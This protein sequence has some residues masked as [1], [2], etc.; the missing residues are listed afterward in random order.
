MSK[1]TLSWLSVIAILAVPGIAW[2]NRYVIFDTWRL[3]N[4]TPPTEIV[5]LADTTTMTG[6]TRR[7]F[8]VYQPLLA[9]KSS[10]STFCTESEQTIVLG[11]YIEHRGIYLYDVPDE[12]LKGVE[13]VTAAHEVLHAVYDRLSRS[14]R[15]RIDTLVLQAFEGIED[16]KLRQT[17][18]NYRKKDPSVVPNELHSILA[19]EVR[20]LPKQ[21]EDHYR[22]YFSDRLAV[23]KLAESYR[24]EFTGREQEVAAL[25]QQLASIKQQIDALN[26]SL[27]QQQISL[28]TSYDTLQND[29]QAGN[30]A[31]YNEGV[32]KYNQQVVRYNADVNKQRQLVNQYNDLVERRN[33]LAVEENELIQALD[34]RSTIEQAQ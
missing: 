25:D 29:K 2:L 10:F 19:T 11:C 31:S 3:R 33:G 6:D 28:K 4:Y 17:V 13:E 27:E 24:Q 1:R 8:Y 26:R 7:L 32:P 20:N 16:A 34:S 21:L 5:Q 14:D 12:R 22:Q 30:V 18:E 15:Q 23:V 9:N